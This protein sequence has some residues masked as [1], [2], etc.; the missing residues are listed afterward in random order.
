MMKNL[1]HTNK[2][3]LKKKINLVDHSTASKKKA[4][5]KSEIINQL[6]EMQDKYSAIEIENKMNQEPINSL[7]LEVKELT[8]KRAINKPVL[9]S[10]LVQ[11]DEILLCHRC[12]FEAEDIYNLEAHTYTHA[13]EHC[14][15]Y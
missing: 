9:T 8:E 4:P 13:P 14:L 2:A 6:K 7:Q 11:T 1:Q 15:I 10:A 5:L 3:E 12:G